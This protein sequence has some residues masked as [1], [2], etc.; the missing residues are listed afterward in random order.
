M[1]LLNALLSLTPQQ[2][3][4]LAAGLGGLWGTAWLVRTLAK[5][6]K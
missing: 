1:E 6:L 4:E 5:V 2:G 3:A